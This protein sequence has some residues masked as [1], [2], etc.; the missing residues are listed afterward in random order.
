M[1]RIRFRSERCG[2]VTPVGASREADG[3]EIER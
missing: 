1:G 2:R 3:G